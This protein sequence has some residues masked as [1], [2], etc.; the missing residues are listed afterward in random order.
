MWRDEVPST[1]Q[2]WVQ[3]ADVATSTPV[4]RPAEH[5]EQRTQSSRASQVPSIKQG[6][7]EHLELW[8]DVFE[9]GFSHSL[10]ETATEFSK[11][12]EPKVAKLKGGYS[13][14]ACLVYLSWLRDLWV[15]VSECH[16]SQ[17]ETIQLIKDYT[18]EHAQFK[19][20]YYLGLTPKSKQSFQGLIDHLSLAFQSCRTV[21]SLIANFYNWSQK[22]QETE[23]MFADELQVLVRK[24]VL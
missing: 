14:D 18:S 17:Q 23:D 5:L 3:F 8:K 10:H 20:E 1:P 6:L 11:L 13:S 7:F 9:E 19:V 24:I 4:P 15:Y 21:G 16:L 22:A 12:Q 2:R